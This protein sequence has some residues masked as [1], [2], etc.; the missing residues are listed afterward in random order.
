MSAHFSGLG[1]RRGQE[2]GP[3]CAVFPGSGSPPGLGLRRPGPPAVTEHTWPPSHP[4]KPN[5]R[6]FRGVRGVSFA[7]SRSRPGLL[8]HRGSGHVQRLLPPVHGGLRSSGNRLGR[9]PSSALCGLTVKRSG[10]EAL[11]RQRW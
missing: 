9:P 1:L 11:L 3:W 10:R 2:P 6:S 8:T 7:S 5:N 4:Y